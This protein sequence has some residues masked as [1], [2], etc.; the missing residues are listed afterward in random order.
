VHSRRDLAESRDSA[1]GTSAASLS[2]TS[3]KRHALSYTTW[4][5]FVDPVGGLTHATRALYIA[6]RREALCTGAINWTWRLADHGKRT[7]IVFRPPFRCEVRRI[8][9][10]RYKDRGRARLRKLLFGGLGFEKAQERIIR[11]EFGSILIPF[12]SHVRRVKGETP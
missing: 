10:G 9:L 6:Q 7:A 3:I 5:K 12:D 2:S 11:R 8:K 1:E 4:S